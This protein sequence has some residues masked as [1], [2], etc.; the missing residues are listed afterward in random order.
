M[1]GNLNT[2]R[3]HRTKDSVTYH[4]GKFQD[5]TNMLSIAQSIVEKKYF[6]GMEHDIRALQTY[7]LHVDLDHGKIRGAITRDE[8]SEAIRWHMANNHSKLIKP[9]LNMYDE[10]GKAMYDKQTAHAEVQH[11]F[12]SEYFS[13]KNMKV[14]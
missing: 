9:Y 1:L 7:S 13:F 8:A 10:K 3:L 2:I 12:M 6:Y 14:Q 5:F 4:A 11:K